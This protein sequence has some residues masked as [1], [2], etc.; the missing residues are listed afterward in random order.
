M[1]EPFKNMVSPESVARLAAALL[2][3]EPVA[4]GAFVRNAT[5][6]LDTLELKAR[7]AHVARAL[8]P[9]LPASFPQA[10]AGLVAALPPPDPNLLGDSWLWPVHVSALTIHPNPA[11][12]GD[13]FTVSARVR[14]TGLGRVDVVWEWPGARGGWSSRTFVGKEPDLNLDQPWVF[15]Q[16][17]SL[18]PVTTRPIR[19]GTQRVWLR[20][21]G[22]AFGP[23][24]FTLLRPEGDVP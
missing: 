15:A 14:G 2:S 12:V 8:R 21:S 3:R 1:A 24:E 6:G 11:R 5:A 17:L 20:I 9:H 19:V 7:V 23:A 4:A 10:L 13:F 16:R 18:R 22:Q